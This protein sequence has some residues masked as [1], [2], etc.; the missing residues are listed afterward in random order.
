M[1]MVNTKTD[2]PRGK[3]NYFFVLLSSLKHS[4]ESISNK[5]LIAQSKWEV[6]QEILKQKNWH[7]QSKMYMYLHA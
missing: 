5:I 7:T 3:T 4:I 1:N 2:F 6:E